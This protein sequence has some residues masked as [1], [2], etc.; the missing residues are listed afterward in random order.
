MDGIGRSLELGQLFD[1]MTKIA[2]D[3]LEEGAFGLRHGD[4]ATRRCHQLEVTLTSHGQEQLLLQWAPPEVRGACGNDNLKAALGRVTEETLVARPSSPREGGL[5]VVLVELDDWPA[6][7]GTEPQALLDL[8]RRSRRRP[9][10]RAVDADV[11]GGSDRHNVL[12]RE[13][14]PR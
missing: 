1:G 6:P 14:S 10:P 7:L 12:L 4:L 11:D 2:D 9:I 8:L 3:R 5:I 13:F